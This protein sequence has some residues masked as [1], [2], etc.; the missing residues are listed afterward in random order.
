VGHV[1]WTKDAIERQLTAVLDPEVGLNVVEMGLIYNLEVGDHNN[2]SVLMTL[3]TP[4]CP[5]HGSIA[6]GVQRMLEDLPDMGEVK[7]TLTF[8][9]PWDPTMMREEAL[10]K[11]GWT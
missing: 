11:L 7:V 2:V 6:E 9:P 1:T 3:T 10:K 4:G 8:E 5:M